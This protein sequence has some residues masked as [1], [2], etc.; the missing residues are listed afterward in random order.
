[1]YCSKC[2]ANNVDDALFCSSCGS[3][4]TRNPSEAKESAQSIHYGTQSAPSIGGK[5]P[6]I[7]AILNFFL[8]GSGYW[9]LGFRKIL[10]LSPLIFVLLIFVIYVAAGWL[11]GGIIT[12]FAALFL[13]YDGYVKAKG[14]RGW[15]STE[16][17]IISQ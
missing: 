4:M 7:V 1:M 5:N 13:A 2:G 15:V 9:Y 17:E 11:T 6:A 10:G 3:S 14:Q 12:F 8:F 16:P